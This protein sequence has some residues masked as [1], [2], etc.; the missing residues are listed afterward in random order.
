LGGSTESVPESAA[1]EGCSA[2]LPASYLLH[3]HD[4]GVYTLELAPGGGDLWA[5]LVEGEAGH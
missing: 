2:E 5:F 1:T 4:T 3:L